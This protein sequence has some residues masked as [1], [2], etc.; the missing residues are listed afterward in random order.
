MKEYQKRI[1]NLDKHRAIKHLGLSPHEEYHGSN[2]HELARIGS[3]ND[4]KKALVPT[5]STSGVLTRA[6]AKLASSINPT[7]SQRANEAIIKDKK[8]L[9]G[10]T[11]LLFAVMSSV[12][13]KRK[14][15]LLHKQGALLK[16]GTLERDSGPI[17]SFITN[18][19]FVK[20]GIGNED[21]RFYSETTIEIN[22]P[23]AIIKA[24]LIKREKIVEMLSKYFSLPATVNVKLDCRFENVDFEIPLSFLAILNNDFS[25]F[26]KLV[27][28][29]Q[30][31]PQAQK[32][33]VTDHQLKRRNVDGLN[34]PSHCSTLKFMLRSY[35]SKEF[36]E[37]YMATYVDKDTKISSF[38]LRS[39][40]M[41]G[42]ATIDQFL[43]DNHELEES[44]LAQIFHNMILRSPPY[45]QLAGFMNMYSFKL[46]DE[47][48]IELL[49]LNSPLVNQGIVQHHMAI[50][51]DLDWHILHTLIN[52]DSHHSLIFLARNLFNYHEDMK[53]LFLPKISS[54]HVSKRVQEII[55][56]INNL[57]RFD[58]IPEQQYKAV[59]NG[60]FNL[61][62]IHADE[63]PL[64]KCL[65]NL[66]PSM[67]Q[68]LKDLAKNTQAKPITPGF[69]DLAESNN[70]ISIEPP[71][72]KQRRVQK[73]Q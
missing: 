41:L 65:K 17:L 36:I 32:L 46:T 18:K 10:F 8:P 67:T 59:L 39:L 61:G 52:N 13:P 57:F 66:N 25:M 6:G 3:Y 38:Y 73:L 16:N 58:S 34:V 42:S 20:P 47:N 12:E 23:L 70:S 50:V 43:L 11:P 7:I 56:T 64:T 21:F 44:D 37:Q 2:V 69:E 63:C 62:L 55:R 26:Q 4:F 22:G 29:Q 71:S 72:S 49:K 35:T 14:I 5:K 28:L 68:Q 54:N 9:R 60:A 15:K 19:R 53:R 51:L 31:Q 1:F 45:E 27:K 48:L 33:I 30:L 24:I 40:S